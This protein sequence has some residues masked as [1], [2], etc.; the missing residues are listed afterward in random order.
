MDTLEFDGPL[1]NANRR[2]PCSVYRCSVSSPMLIAS[3]KVMQTA[4]SCGTSMETCGFPLFRTGSSTSATLR[5]ATS[6]PM[7]AAMEITPSNSSRSGR[8]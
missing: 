6:F 1:M 4:P 8:S 2:A 3:S 5:D 7:V